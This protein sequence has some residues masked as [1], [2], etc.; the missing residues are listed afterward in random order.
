VRRIIIKQQ[1]IQN[2]VVD[3]NIVMNLVVIVRCEIKKVKIKF[4][5]KGCICVEEK[6]GLTSE[7]V[8]LQIFT[9]I[10]D[11]FKGELIEMKNPL[12][13][14]IAYGDD[15]R[16]SY[17]S[18]MVYKKISV[19]KFKNKTFWLCFGEKAKDDLEL[20]QVNSLLLLDK[21]DK[22][23]YY[24]GFEDSRL[25]TSF[26]DG[27]FNFKK[28]IVLLPYGELVNK[29]VVQKSE[30]NPRYL[31]RRRITADKFIQKDILYS[32]DFV[33]YLTEEVLIEYI[34]SL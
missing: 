33:R 9:K 17:K 13:Q 20:D 25:L 22:S 27:S 19:I 16:H 21:L 4:I 7:E 23:E 31:F 14:L 11:Y 32:D 1:Y 5:E 28:E 26:E 12:E 2:A 18:Y 34:Q 10:V 29:F 6:N 3:V 24:N 8:V 15:G 30:L